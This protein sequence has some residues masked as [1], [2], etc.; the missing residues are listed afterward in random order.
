MSLVDSDVLREGLRS[1]MAPAM[2]EEADIGLACLR[3]AFL[4]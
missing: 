3:G 4:K 2:G 1:G